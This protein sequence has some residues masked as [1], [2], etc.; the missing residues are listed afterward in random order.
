[1]SDW[2]EWFANLARREAQRAVQRYARNRHLL[3]TSYNPTTHAVKGTFMPDGV[4]SGWIPIKTQGA[5]ANGISHVTGPSVGDLAVVH[6]SEDDPEAAHVTGWLHSDVDQAP[7]A[8]SGTHVIKHNPSGVTFTL[9]GSGVAIA[10]AG[11]L[12]TINAAN[13]SVNASGNVTINGAM[14]DIN[15]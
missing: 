9:N 1:M 13:V 4:Q 12:V 2:A 11:Q 3:V 8:P 5:S 7:N 14:V 10:A 15:G 6:H